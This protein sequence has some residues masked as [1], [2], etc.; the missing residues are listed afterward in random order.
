MTPPRR[1]LLVFVGSALALVTAAGGCGD[2]GGGSSSS[3][4]G[5]TASTSSPTATSGGDGASGPGTGG[6]GDGGATTTT[7]STATAGG[8][9]GAA[10]SSGE[11]GAGG[12]G[13]GGSGGGEEGFPWEGAL[14]PAAGPSSTRLVARPLGSTEAASGF[15]EYLPP[16]YSEDVAWP[17]LV[18]THGVGENGDGGDDLDRL[19]GSGIPDL[20]DGDAWPNDRP[21]V[22]LMPQHAGDGCPSAEE[23][24]ATITYGIESYAIDPRYVYL[25]GLS[26][27]AIGA[28]RYLAANL[29]SQI[30]AMVPIAGDGRNA[31]QQRGCELGR[32]AIWG[33]H[34]DADPTVSVEGTNVP[35]DGL[36]ACP[37]PPAL[38]SQKTIYPGVGH[39][40]WSRTYDLSAGHDIYAWMLQFHH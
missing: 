1:S 9:G 37:Q 6:G 3:G 16:G 25:T 5:A 8:D 34:G 7:A 30:A 23:I 4:G 11:G 20:I 17:L 35:L 38:P 2:D 21:F 18:F 15:Y 28:W 24:Q 33:F 32:V 40:S 12:S 29:D 26:C 10:S 14:D 27:G 31:W 36:A 39:N 22:V 19:L 13:G